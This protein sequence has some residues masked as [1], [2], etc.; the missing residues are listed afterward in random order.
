M[1]L[2]RLKSYL[3]L[4]FQR[5]LQAVNTHQGSL[6]N[7]SVFNSSG[8]RNGNISVVIHVPAQGFKRS[9]LQELSTDVIVESKVAVCLEYPVRCCA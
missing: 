2:M 4:M 1:R 6:K 9:S 5:R 7:V 8:S 3:R